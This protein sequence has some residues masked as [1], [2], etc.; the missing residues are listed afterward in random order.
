MKKRIIAIIS[1][2]LCVCFLFAGCDSIGTILSG[3]DAEIEYEIK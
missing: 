1:L 2:V 3:E